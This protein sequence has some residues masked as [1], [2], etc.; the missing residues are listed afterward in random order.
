MMSLSRV[1]AK[2]RTLDVR[3]PSTLFGLYL[4]SYVI[5]INKLTPRRI[6][7]NFPE[8]ISSLC[9]ERLSADVSTVEASQVSHPR[10]DLQR[11]S[12]LRTATF[13]K[14]ECGQNSTEGSYGCFFAALQ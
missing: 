2:T 1:C 9:A 11:R 4:G 8:S 7:R 12:S 14:V 13:I 5:R 10:R 3:R 6:Q